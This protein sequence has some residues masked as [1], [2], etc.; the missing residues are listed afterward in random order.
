[1]KLLALDATNKSIEAVMSAGVTTTAPTFA[2]TY[3]DST[4]TNFIEA[5]NTGVLNGTT[6]VT[7][8]A[9]PASSTRRLINEII[10]FN[11]DSVPITVELHYIDGANTRTI[12]HGVIPANG[13]R[14]MEGVFDASGALL[15]GVSSVPTTSLT[16]ILQAAQFP[17]L[18]GDATNSAGS[19]ALTLATVNSNVG[20]F[21]AA[22]LTVDAKGRIT[23]VASG[24]SS[25]TGS[26]LRASAPTVT[27]P[28]I[29]T[30]V[31]GTAVDDDTTLAA[32][33]STKVAT[34]HATKGYVDQ[35]ILG[36]LAKAD[37]Q[38][39][40]AAALAANT[41]ANGS[42]GV[43]ATL[44]GNS[45]GVLTVDGVAVSLN[46]R[47]LVKNEAT[48]ANNGIYKCTT[49]GAG[50]VAYVLT[51]AVDADT[52]IELRGA[53][54]TV[55][56]G[57]ANAAQAFV[58]TNISTITL[59]STAVTF[60]EFSAGVNAAGTGLT[61]TG[62]TFAVDN[63]AVMML[64]GNQSIVG[65]KDFGGA[66]MKAPVSGSVL[67]NAEGNVQ[68][69][70]TDK[71]PEWNDGTRSRF[72]NMGYGPV[73]T[74]PGYS[75]QNTYGGVITLA[76]NGGTVVIP[77]WSPGNFLIDNL[78]LRNNDATLARSWTWAIY[79]DIANAA[80]AI[81]RWCSASGN[82]AYTAVAASNRQ[83]T[84]ASGPVYLP[85][86]NF[87]LVIQNNHASNAFALSSSGYAGTLSPAPTIAMTKTLTPGL[88][89]TLDIVAASWAAT[90][91]SAQAFLFGDYANSTTWM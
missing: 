69:N 45:T 75:S 56:E 19:L 60:G 67:S 14:C 13:H 8:V 17:A 89:T 35:A 25:G 15:T 9:A 41:Y 2:A 58:N 29:N 48:Q 55:Q 46:D 83:L 76:A 33:S 27:S 20:S 85:Q 74:L 59:G 28:V 87:Y 82:S 64:T 21:S 43:G 16:G 54:T 88:G 90:A 11:K 5:P 51:R 81:T 77:F 12:W 10:I 65:A 73:I 53:W 32:N 47:I 37:V 86:G 66:T 34:Q 44:T 24:A 3:A 52:D 63:T 23:A 36:V 78:L 79:V 61:K 49:A 72:Y 39:A 38:L 84:V 70:S 22:D 7:V 40:T 91:S 71:A 62:N 18:T 31:S 6:P 1:M 26:L 68:W 50:G 42:S 57:T 30:G 80:N 4:S